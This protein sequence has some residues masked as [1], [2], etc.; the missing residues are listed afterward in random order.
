MVQPIVLLIKTTHQKYLQVEERSFWLARFDVGNYVM[1]C[2]RLI[3]CVC[4]ISKF[5]TK[6]LLMN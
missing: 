2:S 6:S 4:K 3:L 5:M 1:S